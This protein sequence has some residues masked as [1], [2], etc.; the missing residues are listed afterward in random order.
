MKAGPLGQAPVI[1]RAASSA[2]AFYFIGNSFYANAGLG[3]RTYKYNVSLSSVTPGGGDIKESIATSNLGIDAGIGNRWQWSGFWLGVDWAGYFAP[4][5]KMGDDKVT[6][7]AATDPQDV[8]DAQTNM[9]SLASAGTP[10]L[11][12]VSLGW[13][14]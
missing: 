4:I 7:S 2:R 6:S 8:K 3:L 13:A 5:T 1:P 12:R 11:L 14:F 10:H 9:N